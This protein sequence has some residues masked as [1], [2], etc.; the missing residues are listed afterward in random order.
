MGNYKKFSTVNN[1]LMKLIIITLS[2]VFYFGTFTSAFGQL[3]QLKIGD[4]GVITNPSST[5][6]ELHST[7][8]ALL[9]TRVVSTSAITAPV[10]GMLVYD[11]T[12]NCYK[13]YVNGAWSDCAF[14]HFVSITGKTWMDRNLGATRVAT[15]ATDFLAYGHLYQWGR[16]ADGHQIIGWTS[17]TTGSILNSTVPTLATT[18]TPTHSNPIYIP[19]NND[20]RSPSN[21]LLWQGVSGINNPCPSGFRVPTQAEF[22][23]ETTAYS[24]VDMATAYASPFRFPAAGFVTGNS[25]GQFLSSVG[26]ISRLWTSSMG[27]SPGTSLAVVLFINS[28]NTNSSNSRWSMKSVR[29]VKD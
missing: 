4:N 3:G 23:A 2:I 21:D 18:D 6:L 15:S 16:R 26:S 1:R 20:W 19:G 10:E 22:E 24:I 8:K 28:I 9:I 11:T 5:V 7:N 25:G 27:I 29:C 12:N 17:S 14:Q 13:D